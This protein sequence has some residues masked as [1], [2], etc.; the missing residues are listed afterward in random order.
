MTKFNNGYLVQG[1]T[2]QTYGPL[3]VQNDKGKRRY[4]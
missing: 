4:V 1:V 2:S 3:K